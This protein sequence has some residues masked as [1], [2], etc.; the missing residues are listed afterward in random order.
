MLQ[1][2]EGLIGIYICH[3]L[4]YL[5]SFILHKVV[6]IWGPWDK[7]A[8]LC[9]PE[10]VFIKY[11]VKMLSGLHKKTHVTQS[12]AACRGCTPKGT[13]CSK[14]EQRVDSKLPLFHD[15]LIITPTLRIPSSLHK[16]WESWGTAWFCVVNKT[17][18]FVG[19][20]MG[21]FIGS[22]IYPII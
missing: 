19:G 15:S 6:G 16:W 13:V 4:P 10:T 11:T 1:L 9:K 17:Q 18:V 3:Q 12:Q 2:Q 5:I 20:H 14:E 21:S 22:F 8:N 7:H